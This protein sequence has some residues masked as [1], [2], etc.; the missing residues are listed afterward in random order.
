M[1]IIQTQQTQQTP[2]SKVGQ[3]FHAL[4]GALGLYIAEQEERLRSGAWS[5]YIKRAGE[6]GWHCMMELSYD[7][8][9]DFYRWHLQYAE[10]CE[11]VAEELGL[12]GDKEREALH[13]GFYYVINAS[14]Y[15]LLMRLAVG[16]G[17]STEEVA[18]FRR[19]SAY[20]RRYARWWAK[21]HLDI[22]VKKA[23][24]STADARSWL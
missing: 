11:R 7:L 3:A 21:K 17:T 6:D 4:K 18:S 20:D 12:D 19:M 10:L 8:A 5:H 14:L 2:T 24:F 22:E 1:A 13:E 23:S 9:E 15:S 16:L